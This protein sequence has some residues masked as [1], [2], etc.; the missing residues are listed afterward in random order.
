[1]IDL[2]V[3]IVNYNTKKLL[4]DCL[5][6]I[7]KQTQNI[8]YEIIV[9]DNAS[10]D[11]SVEEIQSRSCGTKFKIIINK[12][13]LGYA[14]ANNIG[15]RQA[16]GKWILLLN[17]DTKI[18]DNA[19][20]KLVD[21]SEGK[22]N[23][24]VLGP[25]L[26]NPDDSAQL[27][28]ARFL[29]LPNVFLWL[30][31]G[32]RFL[33]SSP[34]SAVQTDWVMGSAFLIKREVIDKVGLLDEKFFMYVEEQEWCY[35][36]KKAGFEV[37]FYPGAEIFHLVR[38]SSPGG[39]PAGRQGKKGAILNIYRGLIYFYDKH[40]G[41][42]PLSMLKFMLLTKAIIAWLVGLITGNKELKET[43][44]QAFKLVR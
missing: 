35:R 11:G 36:I 29:T 20:K 5:D 21:F 24:G 18:V 38:G 39:L 22:Q 16:N 28:T 26:L 1:M 9:V 6:S 10:I 33:Y 32:D 19:L 44:A 14:K 23:L 40:F 15:I 37:W 13:N 30:F 25:K 12:S 8:N 34:K 31:T 42:L 4:L 2:S 41:R 3:I 7:V 27:S 43:Y 17:T